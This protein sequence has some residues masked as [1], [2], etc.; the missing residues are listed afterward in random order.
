MV[1]TNMKEMNNKDSDHKKISKMTHHREKEIFEQNVLHEID[2]KMK[3]SE[4][5]LLFYG[6]LK[7]KYGFE[8]YLSIP[9]VANP[10]RF[11]DETVST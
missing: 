3:K 5:K 10:K 7:H 11:P 6:K 2:S 9:N 1:H 4:G 8:N